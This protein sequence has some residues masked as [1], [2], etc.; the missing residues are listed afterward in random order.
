M[1]SIV[2]RSVREGKI[3]RAAHA[4]LPPYHRDLCVGHHD[5]IVFMSPCS[6]AIFAGADAV[7]RA[8]VE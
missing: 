8:C 6:T 4:D 2:P 5:P 7:A 3:V 1:G